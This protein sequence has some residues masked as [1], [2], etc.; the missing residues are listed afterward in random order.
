[1]YTR[2]TI[3]ILKP[4]HWL[5]L[6]DYPL[7]L[8]E[9]D[10]AWRFRAN[11]GCLRWSRNHEL[12]HPNRQLLSLELCKQSGIT[13]K[14]QPPNPRPPPKPTRKDETLKKKTEPPSLGIGLE[15]LYYTG[16]GG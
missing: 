11:C 9:E 3:E 5:R 13:L 8:E 7:N 4:F 14:P 2:A 15:V 1:M 6:P 12:K 16:L 10:E